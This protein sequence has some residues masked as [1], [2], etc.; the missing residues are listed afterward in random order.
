MVSRPLHRPVLG[1]GVALVLL[2]GAAETAMAQELSLNYESL[3]SLEEPLA[4]E[5]GDVTLVLT[6]LLDASMSDHSEDDDAPDAGVIGNAQVAILAQLPNSWRVSLTYFGQYATDA[7]IGLRSD[8]QFIDNGALSVGSAWGTLLVGDVSG[9]VRE[10]TRRRRGA[11]NGV[12]AFDDVLGHLDDPGAGYHGRFG[13]WVVS[14][15]VDRD[16]NLDVGAMFQR[17]AGNRD[18]R[19]AFRATDAVYRTVDGSGR[20]N[21]RAVA[22]VVEMIYGST[23]Y[24]A[25]VGFER[26]ASETWKPDRWF[27]SAGVRTKAG[28][29]GLSIGAHFGRIE[30][31]DECSAALGVQYDIARGL[32][33]NLGFNL[34]RADIAVDGASLMQVDESEAV[35][36][37]RYSF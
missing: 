22:A 35:V 18:Y 31:Q 24:D 20:F 5:I 27:V 25:G 26:L 4:T 1:L 37:I 9:I 15:A 13:P 21:T 6:G 7:A 10:Q 8:E 28:V 2:F 36:S 29:V 3:S 34:A 32:S 17:P 23:T 19:I 33:A 14:T 16:G 11:G 30:G 12:L